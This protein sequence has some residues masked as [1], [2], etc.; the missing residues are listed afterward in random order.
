[1]QIAA[2][3]ITVSCP[4]LAITVTPSLAQTPNRPPLTVAAP[5]T[6]L[7]LSAALTTAVTV[8]LGT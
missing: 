2:L 5:N 8:A 3:I 1:M 6:K 4:A 7:M